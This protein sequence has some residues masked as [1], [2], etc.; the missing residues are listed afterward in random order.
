[1]GEHL[2][3]DERPGVVVSVAAAAAATGAVGDA[4]AAAPGAVAAGLVAGA[5]TKPKN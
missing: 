1:M 4:G 3:D 5:A 2:R